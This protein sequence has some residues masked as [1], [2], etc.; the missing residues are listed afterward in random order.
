MMIIDYVNG[1]RVDDCLVHKANIT[2]W[3]RAAQLGT[4]SLKLLS[5]KLIHTNLNGKTGTTLSSSDLF[6]I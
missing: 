3:R 6:C 2:A 4:K 5:V 1:Y